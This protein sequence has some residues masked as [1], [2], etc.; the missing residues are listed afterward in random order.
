MQA[1]LRLRTG[2]FPRCDDRFRFALQLLVD[3]AAFGIARFPQRHKQN[4]KV[5][6]VDE[7]Q[8]DVEAKLSIR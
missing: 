1:A 6:G 3:D 2:I 8:V 7:E 4:D 5:N